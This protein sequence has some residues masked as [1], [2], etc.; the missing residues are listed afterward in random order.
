LKFLA[1]GS[2]IILRELIKYIMPEGARVLEFSPKEKKPEEENSGL[3]I[4]EIVQ[5]DDASKPPKVLVRCELIDGKVRLDGDEDLLKGL[6]EE[7]FY[8]EGERVTSDDGERFLWAIRATYHNPYLFARE[9][10]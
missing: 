1:R 3:K 8:W 4:L 5:L 7:E 9:I 6:R 2:K 10:K